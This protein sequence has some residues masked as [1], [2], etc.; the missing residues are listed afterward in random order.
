MNLDGYPAFIVPEKPLVSIVIP[1]FNGLS[2]TDRCVRWVDAQTPHD[3]IEVIVVDDCS[4]DGTNEYL[5]RCAGI[6]VIRNEV[7]AGFLT[8]VNNGAAVARGEF[9]LFLNNDTAVQPGW[10]TALLD[11]MNSS[12]DVAAAGSQL[13]YPD[14]TLQEAGGVI[15]SDARG[16]NYGRGGS[17]ND[18]E[19]GFR[20]EVDYCSAAALIVRRDLFEQLGGFDIRFAPGYY[21]DTDLC[22]SLRSRG[23]K[24]LYEPRSI[25]IHDEG[26]TFG[27][28]VLTTP[29]NGHGKVSQ[30]INRYQFAAKWATQLHQHWPYGTAN[31][32]LGGRIDPRP[33][34]LIVDHLVPTPDR[35]SGSLRMHSIAALF[36]QLECHVTLFPWNRAASQPYTSDLQRLGVEVHYGSTTFAEFCAERSC[37]YDVV[38]L[39]RPSFAALAIGD[40]ER[41]FPE[42]LTLYDTVDLHFLREQRRLELEGRLADPALATERAVELGLI[43]RC[44]LTVTV[45]EDEARMVE[46]DV[47]GTR[48]I[49][50]PNV[51]APVDGNV[52]GPAGRRDLLFIGGFLHP[53]NVDA[54]AWFVGDVLPMIRRQIDVNLWIL[55]SEPPPE[56][57]QLASASVRVTGYIPDVTQ[58]FHN[59]RIFVAPLRYGAGM[60][61]KLGQAMTLGLPVVTTSIGAEG[62]RMSDGVH[63]LVRDQSE[64][65]AQAV[66]DLYRDDALWQRLSQAARSAVCGLFGPDAMRARLEAL[67]LELSAGHRGR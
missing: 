43:A 39:S 51:H 58:H 48:T 53:P 54:M 13:V 30:F 44:D 46:E 64:G 37:I 55:G 15:W 9:V 32:L 11:A 56:V 47:P 40:V 34:I 5:A 2:L 66:V 35:D 45:T 6:K 36:R 62:M 63:M 28:D 14:G 61:G 23:Y 29:T 41:H 31:G 3:L 26:A 60:K 24:V 16:W 19:Y 1:V 12:A 22:F 52:P 50:L 21:E 57:Q 27:T 38:I 8:S 25:V 20:R 18:P 7:N 49:V 17:A 10:L 65:F 67:L 4:T 42:A 33:R 59:A